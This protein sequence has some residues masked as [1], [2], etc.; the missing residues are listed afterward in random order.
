M[1]PAALTARLVVQ[2]RERGATV[3]ELSHPEGDQI[4]PGVLPQIRELLSA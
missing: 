2:L 3:V 4:H 1:I